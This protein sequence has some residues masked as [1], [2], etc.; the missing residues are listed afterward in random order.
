MENLDAFALCGLQHQPFG[1][2]RLLD[3]QFVAVV[4]VQLAHVVSEVEL[5]E[6]LIQVL[7]ANVMID[8]INATAN[9]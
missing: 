9:D 5:T 6:V 1:P 7:L 4:I 2:A 8:A 3:C